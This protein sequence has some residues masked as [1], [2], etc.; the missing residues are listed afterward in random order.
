ML[1]KKRMIRDLLDRV[2]GLEHEAEL[3]RTVLVVK[4]PGTVQAAQTF[5]GL[6]KQILASAAERRSHLAQL[7]AMSVAVSRASSVADLV[8]Q[9][10]DWM[11]QAG[12]TEVREVPRGVDPMDLFEDLCGKGL[13]GVLEIV[14]PAYVDAE[15]GA[16]LRLGRARLAKPKSTP[17][18]VAEPAVAVE[19]MVQESALPAEAVG[20]VANGE[21]DAE[22]EEEQK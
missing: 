12:V 14:E 21:V 2:K 11:A 10:Q 1:T 22:S 3:M 4:E 16:L 17:T 5:D 13:H 8:P 18:V 15:T 9:V 7:V 6:R 20:P 19:P